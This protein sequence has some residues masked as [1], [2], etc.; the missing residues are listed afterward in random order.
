MPKKN[1]SK[2]SRK[3]PNILYPKKQIVPYNRSFATHPKA[4]FWSEKNKVNPEDVFLCANKKYFFNCDK[5]AHDFDINLNNIKKGQWCPFCAGSKL[6]GDRECDDCYNKS[7]AT[8]PKADFWSEKN[9][10]KPKDV[11]LCSNKKYFFDCYECGHDFDA[12]LDNIKNGKWCPFCAGK[13]L[14]GDSDC[15]NCNKKSFASHPKAKHWS[16]KNKVKPKDVYLHSMK[17]Y[18]FDCDKCGH[19]FY[20]SLANL[21]NGY[22]CHYCSGRKICGEAE[23]DDCFIK[24]F[25]SHNLEEYWSLENKLKPIQ[26]SLYSNIKINFNCNKCDH[27]FNAQVCNVTNGQWCPFCANQKLCNEKSCE[28]CKKKSFVSHE[29]SKYWSKKNKINPRDVFLCSG[30]KYFFKCPDCKHE[31]KSKISKIKNGTWC[32]LCTNK[33]EKTL[34][35][36]LLNIYPNVIYNFR[37]DWCKSSETK[38][39]YPFDICIP[40]LKIIIELDGK[41]HFVQVS[42][43]CNPKLTHERDIYK[44]KC[45]S[46]NDY[47]VIR[48]LQEDVYSNKYDWKTELTDNI[49]KISKLTSI[50]NIFM[51]KKNEYNIFKKT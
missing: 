23:C 3:L 5:C 50:K 17:K 42:N 36:F 20:V 30:K 6:C 40:E 1:K 41:Q 18:F 25:A 43:W 28:D 2:K 10:V 9:K 4:E 32:P 26:V 29:K 35:K 12:S 46:K 44:M 34:Y 48:I 27:N 49:K 38:K 8:H 16:E 45:A 14:C 19:D 21:K 7:F 24:S 15:D 51:C 39:H 31:F 22:W 11:F 13:K 37:T 33:T 47:S